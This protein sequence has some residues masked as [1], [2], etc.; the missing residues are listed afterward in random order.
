MIFMKRIAAVFLVSALLLTGCNQVEIQPLTTVSRDE[1]E[2]IDLIQTHHADKATSSA[3][4]TTSTLPKPTTEPNIKPVSQTS[5]KRK[6]ASRIEIHETGGEDGR[7]DTWLVAKTRIGYTVR[8]SNNRMKNVR[9]YRISEQDY[10]D[11]L[12]TDVT[13]YIGKTDPM[14]GKVCDELIYQICVSY[15]D[16]TSDDIA[17]CVPE[18]YEKLNHICKIYE[19]DIISS[20]PAN[21]TTARQ[22]TTQYRPT[23]T[24]PSSG[25]FTYQ[26]TENTQGSEYRGFYLDEE[27]DPDSPLYVYISSGEKPSGGYSLSVEEITANGNSV[28]IIVKETAPEP[29]QAVT[30]ALTYPACVVAITPKPEDVNVRTENGNI[31]VC[32]EMRWTDTQEADIVYDSEYHMKYVKNQLLVQVAPEAKKYQMREV[33]AEVEASIIGILEHSGDYQ[34]VFRSDKS[35]KDLYNLADRISAYSFVQAACPD[36]REKEPA[37]HYTEDASANDLPAK[38]PPKS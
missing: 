6:T 31:M 36:I 26:I 12:S 25:Q 18:L 4:Q 30:C 15:T 9:E 37:R 8:Y 33:A 35:L 14:L 17:V 24:K 32:G 29:A 27:E 7:D 20:E 16:G 13:D 5:S 34:L 10:Q 21:Q 28:S 19:P 23:E 3:T 22:T 38:T 2:P 11:I 1:L